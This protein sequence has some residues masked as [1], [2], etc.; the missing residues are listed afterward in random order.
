MIALCNDID[1]R[2]PQIGASFG[3]LALAG[4]DEARR[5]RPRMGGAQVRSTTKRANRKRGITGGRREWRP[6][7]TLRLMN[8]VI[9]PEWTVGY[10][11]ARA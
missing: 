3:T 10:G 4:A 8:A 6:A 2:S 11:Q 9:I 5:Q 1:Q 7:E